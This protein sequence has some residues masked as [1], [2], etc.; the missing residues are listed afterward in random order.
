LHICFLVSID[1][2]EVPSNTMR[3]RLL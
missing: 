2:A 1:I 3:V